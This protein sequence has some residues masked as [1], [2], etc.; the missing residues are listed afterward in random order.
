MALLTLIDQLDLNK[1]LGDNFDF[2]PNVDKSPY[3]EVE[4][5]EYSSGPD[6]I[7]LSSS[8]DNTKNKAES[9]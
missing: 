7:E 2:N 9:S 3:K 1:S 6:K 4:F 5:S 8:E